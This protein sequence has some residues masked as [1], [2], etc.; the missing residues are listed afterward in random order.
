[1]RR[2]CLHPPRLAQTMPGGDRSRR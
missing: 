1:V 2:L